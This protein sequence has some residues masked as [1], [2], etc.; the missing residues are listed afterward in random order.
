MEAAP[1][2]THS[3]N[4]R[5]EKRKRDEGSGRERGKEGRGKDRRKEWGEGDSEGRRSE[6]EEGGETSIRG[7]GIH[8]Q[9]EA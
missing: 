7:L 4:Q 6:E 5:I 1:A 2:H 8:L 3:L 9:R